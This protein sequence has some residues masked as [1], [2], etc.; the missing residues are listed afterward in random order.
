MIE[1]KTNAGLGGEDKFGA[2]APA[3]LR[4]PI[5]TSVL[6]SRNGYLATDRYSGS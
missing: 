5:G 4:C 3:G 2:R 6:L 1:G